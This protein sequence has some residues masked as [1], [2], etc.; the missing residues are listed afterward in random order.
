[1][2]CRGLGNALLLLAALVCLVWVI[3]ASALDTNVRIV[4]LSYINGDVQ[5]DRREGQGYEPAIL[6]MPIIQGSRLWTRGEDALAE[7]E[8]EDGSTVR[9]T[10][11]TALEFQELSLRGSGEKVTA[12]ELESGTA[13]FDIRG[14]MGDFRVTSG[15]QQIN[16]SHAARFRVFGDNGEFKVAVYKGN[17]AVRSGDNQ[18][19]V[20]DGETFTLDLSDL[21]RYNLAKSIEEGSYDDWNQQRER[22]AQSYSSA[23]TYSADSNY[24]DFSPAYS[25]GLADLA[26]YGNYFYAP[27]WGWMWRPYYMGAGWNPFMDGSWLWYP[28]FGYAWVSPYPWGWMPYRYGAWN[29]VPGYGW[30][31]MPTSTWTRWASVPV[32]NQRPVGWV[33]I[34]PPA[35]AP[36]PGTA[37]IVTV[38]RGWKP[39]YPPGSTRPAIFGTGLLHSGGQLIPGQPTIH[40]GWEPSPMIPASS[41]VPNNGII[42]NS[43][44]TPRPPIPAATA[45]AAARPVSPS[46]VHAHRD[47]RV[48]H[49]APVAPANR[50]SPPSAAPRSQF[51]PSAGGAHS[52]G[53]GH[54]GGASAGHSSGGSGGGHGGGHR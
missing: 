23:S 18:I 51:S 3:P 31:W 15:G 6:N 29:F 39:A 47:S 48:P 52:W 53:G 13:Y 43:T 45:P 7:V 41:W 37:G 30:C 16:V 24:S 19:A 40:R 25:Y 20:R 9:L 5:L 2:T 38:G 44:V 32:V 17:V 54:A 27:G 49:A 8:F 12:V 26:Y 33:P 10:P 4:R 50:P 34:H 46:A 36:K 1:M 14:H 42:T 21:S 22:Y 35:A 11:G 28:Q